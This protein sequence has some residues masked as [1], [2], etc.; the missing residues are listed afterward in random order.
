MATTPPRPQTGG[1]VP[2]PLAREITK[3]GG[4]YASPPPGYAE[5][6]G[7]ATYRAARI[8][9]TLLITATGDLPNLNQIAD[10]RQLPFDVFPPQFAMLF[11]TPPITLPAIQHFRFTKQ[12]GF[13]KDVPYAIVH[14]ADGLHQV[15]IEDVK[16]DDLPFTG[17]TRTLSETSANPIEIGI[18]ESLQDALNQAV[19]RLP[20]SNPHV[21]DGFVVYTILEAGGFRGGFAG[22]DRH[23]AKVEAR[24]GVKA[25]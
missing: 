6:P 18:G 7:R 25:P 16:D 2:F 22:A 19:A 20:A 4:L 3:D 21:A 15:N 13:P 12:F 14:D 17:S 9:T 1:E 10:L 24:F 8:G 11:Y 23:Y 5:S